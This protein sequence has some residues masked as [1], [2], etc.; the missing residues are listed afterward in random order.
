MPLVL[1]VAM[2][3]L[4]SV[5]LLN[6]I[7]LPVLPYLQW[8][9]LSLAPINTLQRAL[10]TWCSFHCPWNI[11][12]GVGNTPCTFTAFLISFCSFLLMSLVSGRSDTRSSH[13]INAVL[14]ES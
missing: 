14:G 9:S 4:S 10:I 5:G 13:N 3:W 7:H 2:D 1:G 12:D 6:S 11:P 8:A